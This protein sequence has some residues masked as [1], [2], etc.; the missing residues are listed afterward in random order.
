MPW[1]FRLILMFM[2]MK[3]DNYEST[4]QQMGYMVRPPS[5]RKMITSP[6][7][8]QHPQ[9]LAGGARLART[10]GNAPNRPSERDPPSNSAGYL[11]KTLERRDDQPTTYPAIRFPHLLRAWDTC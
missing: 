11:K 7:T 6:N 3:G 8:L 1:W 2:A 9:T 5:L 10:R 4:L